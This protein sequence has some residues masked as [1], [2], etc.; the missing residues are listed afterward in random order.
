MRK[1]KLFLCSNKS[2][3]LGDVAFYLSISCGWVLNLFSFTLK[4]GCYY[5]EMIVR[6][7][8]YSLNDES[9]FDWTSDYCFILSY[10]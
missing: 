9:L 8:R 4:N 7:S 6:D 1:F 5:S 10:S 2:C 3:S